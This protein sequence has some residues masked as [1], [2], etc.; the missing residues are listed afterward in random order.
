MPALSS[1]TLPLL[2]QADAA[3]RGVSYARERASVGVVH[4][5]LGAFH[6]AHQ[7]MVFD[8]L[9]A[10]GDPRWGIC[11]VAMHSTELATALAAQDGLYSVQVASHAGRHWQVVGAMLQSCVAA[12]E[13]SRVRDAMAAPATRWIT[14]TVTEKGYGPA[15]GDLLAHGLA[16]RHQAGEDGLTIASCDNLVGNGRQL[17]TLCLEAATRL[18]ASGALAAW[19]SRHCTFP[20]S[21]VDRIVPAA[22]PERRAQ[23]LSAL[24]L[25][26]TCALGTEGFWEWVI[27]RRFADPSDAALLEGAGVRVVDDVAP[28]ELAKLRMLNGSHTAIACMGAVAGLPTVADTVGRPE[29]ARFVRGLM[30]V[31]V[32]P[33]VTRPGSADYRDALLAR[34]VNPDLRHSVH[35]IATDSSQKI[36]QRWVPSA[37]AQLEQGGAIEHLAFAAAAWMRYQTGVS[38]DGQAYR[39]ADPLADVTQA[40]A[41]QHHGDAAATVDALL[42]VAAIWGGALPA[43]AQWRSRVMHWL[44]RI[45]AQGMLPAVG[46]FVDLRP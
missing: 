28:F 44:A 5:G 16:A 39:L 26:D 2:P 43:H 10:A 45:Q 29:V 9:L 20:S 21:M 34:F 33:H 46:D 38:D 36:P 19:I 4:L 18:D 15:L 30:T 35:Q 27:E 24:G 40:L 3:V 7:A 1:S 11:G 23:A 42:G 41:L 8:A 31:E 12:R 22:T 14:L 25:D 13:P 6:R 37:L 17:L 32:M